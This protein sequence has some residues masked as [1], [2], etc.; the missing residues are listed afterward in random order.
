MLAA[1][2]VCVTWY[3]PVPSGSIVKMSPLVW[4]SLSHR[5]KTIRPFSGRF[6]CDVPEATDVVGIASIQMDSPETT[7]STM[8]RRLTKRRGAWVV[9]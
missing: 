7:A 1:F 4:R 2:G 6:I 8:K 5:R 3:K 9:R